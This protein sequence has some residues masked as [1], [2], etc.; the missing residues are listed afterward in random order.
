M[1][2]EKRKALLDELGNALYYAS[3]TAC[4]LGSSLEEVVD[5][6]YGFGDTR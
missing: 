2:S 3:R 4:E 6:L 1:T 5:V